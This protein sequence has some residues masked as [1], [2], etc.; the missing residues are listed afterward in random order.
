MVDKADARHEF[1]KRLGQRIADQRKALGWT[2]DQLAEQL[3]VDAE[4]VSRFERGV[5]IPALL[6]LDKLAG[7]LNTSA[8]VLLT[9]A[10]VGPS[11]PAMR[12]SAWLESLSS[13]NSDFVVA[14]VKTLCD[15]LRQ[16]QRKVSRSSKARSLSRKT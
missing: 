3:S 14:Q 12:I 8:S 7:I 16:Q 10:S 9:D 2:Q 5:A 13:E 15:Y 4:T 1:G 11:A 6:T